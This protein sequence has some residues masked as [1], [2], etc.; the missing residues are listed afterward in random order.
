MN[1]KMLGY[2]RAFISYSQYEWKNL[3]LM[4][5]FAIN[6]RNT[7]SG[8]SPFFAIHGYY[9][10]LVQEAP[11]LHSKKRTDGTKAAEAFVTRLHEK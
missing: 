10:D 6:N 3:L 4:A 8:L 2:L 11:A 5:M 1:Q 9:A 7:G